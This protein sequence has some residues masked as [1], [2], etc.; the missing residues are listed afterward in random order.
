MNIQRIL[1][2][3]YSYIIIS[4]ILGFGLAAIF[5]PI[6]STSPT[7][8][9]ILNSKWRDGDHCYTLKLDETNGSSYKK[10]D[11]AKKTIYL[12]RNNA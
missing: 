2:S 6:L 9:K 4:I 11:P 5:K 12:D 3:K 1:Y 8:N 7:Y 10:C